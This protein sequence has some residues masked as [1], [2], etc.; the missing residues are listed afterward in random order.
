MLRIGG[1]DSYSGRVVSQMNFKGPSSSYSWIPVLL[2][3]SSTMC[4]LPTTTK[5]MWLVVKFVFSKHLL[6]QPAV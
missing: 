2:N 1:L 3:F 4:L 6:K 5:I